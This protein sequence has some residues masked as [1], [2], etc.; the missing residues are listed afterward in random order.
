M[1]NLSARVEALESSSNAAA[2]WVIIKQTAD[3]TEDEAVAAYE[4]ANGSIG[5]SNRILMVVIR[6][7]G[8]AHV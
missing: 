7:P 8:A 2:S 6:K 1:R 5:D 4:E 3:Q